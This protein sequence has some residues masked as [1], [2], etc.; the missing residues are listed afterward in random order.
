MVIHDT[1]FYWTHRF[2]HWRPVFKYMHAAHHRS[3]SPTPW[4]IF[5]FSPAEAV[6][7]F[8]VFVLI[9]MFIPLHPLALFT[10][11]F[12]DT[13]MNTGGHT[14][15]ELVPRFI[16]KHPLYQGLNT[17]TDHDRHHTNMSKNFGS[18]FNVWDRW[19]GTFEE[20]DEEDRPKIVAGQ[21]A[22]GLEPRDARI[23]SAKREPLA[24]I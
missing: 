2:M 3:I 23:E 21:N 5:A 15:Y 16:A 20:C 7:Q 19:M 11:L 4:A 22:V 6:L 1:Y 10:F 9:V 13:Q 17:V 24:S 14:G 18:F 8:L 12:L